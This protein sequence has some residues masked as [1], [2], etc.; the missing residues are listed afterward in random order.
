[1]TIDSFAHS[2]HHRSNLTPTKRQFFFNR[3]TIVHVQLLAH[4]ADYLINA[5]NQR[6]SFICG[7]AGYTEFLSKPFI[8]FSTKKENFITS[9]LVPQVSYSRQQMLTYNE[10]N[11]YQKV[12]FDIHFVMKVILQSNQVKH[13]RR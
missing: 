4:R 5:L 9:A 1:M 12:N 3:P 6:F 10:I 8:S 7:T 13:S 2:R 11:K